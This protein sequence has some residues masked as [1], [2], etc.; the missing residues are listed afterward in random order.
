MRKYHTTRFGEIEVREEDVVVV[1]EG[2]LGFGAHKRY[3]LLEDPQ[4]EPF[5]WFQSLDDPALAFVLVDPLCFFPEY[6]VSVPR[7]EIAGLEL[8]EPSEARILAV[9]VVSADPTRITANLKG[10]LILNPRN[11]LAKQVVLLDE[12][13]GTQQPLL[14]QL[15]GGKAS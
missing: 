3:I 4:Q 15:S 8:S 12:R 11:R 14:A 1:S 7:E 13:Y 5:L 6:R 2:L 10:P 9:V